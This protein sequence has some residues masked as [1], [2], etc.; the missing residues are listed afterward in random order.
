MPQ[1]PDLT[2]P[3]YLDEVGWF[4]YHER[5]ARDQFGGSYDAERLAYSRLLLDEVVRYLGKETRWIEDKAIVS[6]GCGCTGDLAAFPAAVKI[7]I[8][9][10]LYVYQQLGML[11]ADEAG[12]QTVHLSIGVQ[13]IPLLDACADLVLC[14]NALDH[15]PEP[16]GAL[17]EF[18]RILRNDGA[19]FMSVDIGGTPTPDE[20]IVFSVESL[21]SLLRDDFEVATLTDNHPPHSVGRFCSLRILAR[22][23]PRVSQPVDKERI[24]SAYEARLPPKAE[25][26]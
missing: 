20:P 19:L 23:K 2:D 13:N 10:L 25:N 17:K 12:S 6:I 5:Y 3:R 16:E 9:P 24:L 15:M 26:T 22:K 1:I 21:R 14:R 11:I 4:L 8:D 18:W 7:A